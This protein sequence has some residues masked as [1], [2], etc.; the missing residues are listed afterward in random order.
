MDCAAPPRLRPLLAAFSAIFAFALSATLLPAVL[1]RAAPALG[2]EESALAQVASAQFAGFFCATLVGGVLSDRWGM[3]HVLRGGCGLMAFGALVWWRTDSL[4]MAY[5]AGTVMGMGGGVVESMSSAFL[6]EIFAE[7]RKR[8]LNL[9]QVVFCLGALG[10][11]ALMAWLLPR[12][13]AWETG[14]LAVAVLSAFSG[15]L[16]FTVTAPPPHPE[17]RISRAALRRLCNHAGLFVPLLAM[18]CYVLSE[19]SVVIHCNYYLQQHRLA[20]EEWAIASIS[21]VW[22]CVMVGRLLC[23]CI[24]E[25]VATKRILTLLFL[26]GAAAL[27]AQGLVAD[28]RVSF[29]L[30]S[31]SGLLFAG[32]WPLLVELTAVWNPRHTATA[33][34]LTIAAGAL[35]VVAAPPLM[36]VAFDCLPAGW[37]YGA[38]ALPLLLGAGLMQVRSPSAAGMDDRPQAG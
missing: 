15:L 22:F 27:A 31:V 28:W 12:G 32:T 5:G 8:V 20:P 36:A 38:A 14:F 21:A 25:G 4:A 10:G 34:G 26:G 7:Q 18:F 6:A 2:V 37:V 24:P 23:A 33:V 3:A 29:A 1:L 13:L 17:E 11:P 16:F 19:S 30:F 9:S 35:G